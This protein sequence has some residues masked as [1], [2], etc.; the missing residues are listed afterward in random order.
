MLYLNEL[1]ARFCLISFSFIFTFMLVY[2]YKEVILFLMIKPNY[3]N[4]N[5]NNLYFIFTNAIEIFYVYLNLTLF[6]CFQILIV[7]STYHLSLFFSPALVIKEFKFLYSTVLYLVILWVILLNIL[8]F[9]IIPTSWGFFLSFQNSYA[10][11]LHFEAKLNE[12]L[13]FYLN[14]YYLILYYSSF[15]VSLFFLFYYSIN[16]LNLV[17]NSRKFF[18]FNFILLS[19]VV[20]PPEVISQVFLSFFCVFIYEIFFIILLLK[21]HTKKTTS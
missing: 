9:F 4:F 3:I 1:K 8:N 16:N 21:L 19:T 18:Y 10:V 15:F 5:S 11:N 2:F 6:C 20:T 14:L 12:Y 7:Y 17:K 13:R